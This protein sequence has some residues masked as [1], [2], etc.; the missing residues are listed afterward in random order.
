M[1]MATIRGI[2]KDLMEA[3]K[4]SIFKHILPYNGRGI[5]ALNSIMDGILLAVNTSYHGDMVLHVHGNH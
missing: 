4:W 1:S 2:H 5:Y 3:L